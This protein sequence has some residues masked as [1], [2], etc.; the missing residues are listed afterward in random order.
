LEIHREI[1]F[2]V[3]SGRVSAVLPGWPIIDERSGK[4]AGRE[5]RRFPSGAIMLDR[6]DI[7]QFGLVVPFAR[8]LRR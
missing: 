5:G 8:W 4:A 7:R 1:F 6:T 2:F 3:Q